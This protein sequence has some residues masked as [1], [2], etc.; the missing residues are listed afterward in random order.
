MPSSSKIEIR[1]CDVAVGARLGVLPPVQHPRRQFRF[2]NERLDCFY[3]VVVKITKLS[4]RVNAHCYAR[5]AGEHESYA[6]DLA[7]PALDV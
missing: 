5:S 6:L 1:H 2:F 3:L 4:F 7:Q